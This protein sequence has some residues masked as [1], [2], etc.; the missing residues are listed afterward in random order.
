MKPKALVLDG[1]GLNCGYET[2]YSLK[3]AGAEAKRVHI[4]ELIWGKEKLEDYHILVLIG[5]F[6]WGDDHGAGVLEA[7]K[8]KFNMGNQIRKFIEDEKLI[9]GICN[10]FQALV[11]SGLLPGIKNYNTREIALISNDMGNFRDDW[12]HLRVRK[13]LCIFT[14]GI[15]GIDLPIRHGEGKF[16]AEESVIR[17]LFENNQIVLQYAKGDK[18]A[19]G[20]FP[21]NPNGS[22]EDIAGITDP[23]G[24]IFGL[25]PH[26][27]AF[28][29]FT[30]HPNWTREKEVL[31]R[32]GKPIPE[33]GDGIKIFRN[34]VRYVEENLL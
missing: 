5:G 21:Y 3:L 20:E 28:N 4:N 6:S 2:A 30:N 10:G 9:M 23:T 29:S 32:S 7:C 17:K 33:E 34:A 11:N 12:V 16:Y 19:N 24:R 25:M 14:K 15:K 26:P 13:S 1:Y 8:L 27:E 22:L 31:K 18:L